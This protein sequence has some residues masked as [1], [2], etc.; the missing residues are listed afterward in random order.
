MSDR[1]AAAR[2]IADAVLYEGYVLYPYRASAAKNQVRWTFGVLVPPEVAAADPSERSSNRTEVLVVR[3][4][5]PVLHVRIRCLQVQQRTRPGEPPWDEAVDQD[6]DLEPLA[7]GSLPF[8]HQVPIVLPA[9]AIEEPDGTVRRRAA[10]QGSVTVEVAAV[11]GRAELTRV[12]VTVT[13]TTE[14]APADRA[15]AARYS[16]VAAHTLLA[17]EGGAF[18][19][20][21]E[22]PEALADAVTGCRN[23]GVFPVL[24]GDDDRLVLA[25]PI[26]LYDRPAVAPQSPGDLYDACEIDEILALRI[27]TLTDEEKAE[28]RATDPRAAGIIDRWD[29]QPPEVWARLHGEMR[30]VGAVDEA[31][32][33]WDERVDEGYDPYADELLIGGAVVTAGTKVRLHPSRR[34]DAQDMFLAD[35]DATVLGVFTDVDDEVL[36]SVTV[37]DDPAAELFAAQRRGYFFHPDELEVRP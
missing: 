24:V 10:V 4:D 32:P 17:V 16:L 7:L 29:D 35:M 5:T 6:L 34:A 13:N 25:S 36:V 14:A 27:L 11:D 30:P 22:P 37:D 1:F 28:A 8:T 26:I 21:L 20:M 2:P 23:D 19:S 15:D 33:W 3:G 31:L 18:V 12:A 9:A